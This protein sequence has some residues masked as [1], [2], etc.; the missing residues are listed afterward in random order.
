MA[1][2]QDIWDFSVS[3]VRNFIRRSGVARRFLDIRHTPISDVFAVTTSGR[4]RDV[5]MVSQCCSVRSRGHPNLEP[6]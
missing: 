6:N 1:S 4:H 3:H 5:C 2:L